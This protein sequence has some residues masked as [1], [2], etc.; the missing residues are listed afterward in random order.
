M[1][2]KG[3][4]G[5][6]V[7]GM[8]IQYETNL[9]EICYCL[10][11]IDEHSTS[12]VGKIIIPSISN[13]QILIKK[14]HLT[15]YGT[16]VVF[17]IQEGVIDKVFKKEGVIIWDLNNNELRL[18][19]WFNHDTIYLDQEYDLSDYKNILLICFHHPVHYYIVYLDEGIIQNRRTSYLPS[20]VLTSRQLENIKAISAHSKD[21]KQPPLNGTLMIAPDGT[22][23]TDSRQGYRDFRKEKDV[24]PE[25]AMSIYLGN[26]MCSS[27]FAN[28]ALVIGCE[29]GMILI[30]GL[31]KDE[32]FALLLNESDERV[33]DVIVINTDSNQQLLLAAQKDD[34]IYIWDMFSMDY[35]GYLRSIPGTDIYG[36]DFHNAIFESE[37]VKRLISMNGGQVDVD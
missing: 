28:N 19:Y 33:M 29:T 15:K 2:K 21:Q 14:V 8:E 1:R 9:K 35:M 10:H 30:A 4:I 11:N 12:P 7:L 5:A 27:I 25:G 37:T 26:A 24:I 3:F 13:R 16:Y 32:E 34:N 36:C 17:L 31:D 18:L 6:I 22:I 23:V 20:R